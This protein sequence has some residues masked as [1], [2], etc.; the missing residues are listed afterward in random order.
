MRQGCPLSPSLFTLLIADM[1][2]ELEK[3]GG[4]EAGGE[5]WSLAYADD[6]AVLAEDEEGMRGMIVK[7]E[8]YVDGK[9]L[10]VNVGKTKVMRCRRGGGGGGRRWY[11]GG[12]GRNWKR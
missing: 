10:Q 11:G 2:E 1:D 7:L 9:G 12:R 6:V 5:V 3:G 8:K 4:G